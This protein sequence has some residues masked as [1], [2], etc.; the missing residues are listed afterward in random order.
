MQC[1]L[2]KGD[3]SRKRFGQAGFPT[4]M[5]RFYLAWLLAERG[6]FDEGVLHGREGIGIA[7]ALDHP[8]I[9][10]VSAFVP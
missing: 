4:A 7:E 1:P 2:F 3:L 5:A 10:V 6:Q 8:C 9:P